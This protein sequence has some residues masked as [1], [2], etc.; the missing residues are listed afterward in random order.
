MGDV[1][2]VKPGFARNYLLPQ[3]KAV[4]ASDTSRA[5]FETKR[6]QLEADNLRKLAIERRDEVAEKLSASE[7]LISR[8]LAHEWLMHKR[9]EMGE[10]SVA[11]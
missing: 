4:T 8:E 10:R 1:A 11:R 5:E 2:N 9:R 6:A 3:H 7:Y